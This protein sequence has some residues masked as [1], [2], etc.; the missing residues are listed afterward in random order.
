MVAAAY[1][2]QRSNLAKSLGFGRK[3][4]TTPRAVKA[5]KPPAKAK[6]KPA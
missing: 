6:G 1:S 2:A 3:A 4:A 5:T